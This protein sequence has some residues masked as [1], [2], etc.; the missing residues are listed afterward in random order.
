MGVGR[1]QKIDAD[2]RTKY[3]EDIQGGGKKKDGPTSLNR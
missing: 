2:R 3:P 1:G